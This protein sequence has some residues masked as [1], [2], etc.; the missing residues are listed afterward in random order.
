VEVMMK[1]KKFI[2]ISI[3]IILIIISTGVFVSAMKKEYNERDTA[4][5]WGIKDEEILL[6]D[7]K[8]GEKMPEVIRNPGYILDDN[9]SIKTNELKSTKEIIN[10]EFIEE[11]NGIIK[12]EKVMSLEEFCI[13]TKEEVNS[14]TQISPKRQVLVVQVHY[15]EGYRHVRIGFVEN[16]FQTNIYDA[17]TGTYIG[18]HTK[19]LNPDAKFEPRP[20]RKH[21]KND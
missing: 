4:P 17:E 6:N 21:I 1:N 3:V 20:R 9:S 12:L 11:N 18:T 16:A 7:D 5:S 10:K 8:S 19:S 14:F 13:L 15:P 2:I